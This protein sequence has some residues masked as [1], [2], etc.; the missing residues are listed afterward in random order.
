MNKL[1]NKVVP[2]QLR[3]KHLRSSQLVATLVVSLIAGCSNKAHE[4][5]DKKVFYTQEEM[6][7]WIFPSRPIIIGNA[8]CN[9]S[10]VNTG[11]NIIDVSIGHCID[12][13]AWSSGKK[14]PDYIITK[15][16]LLDYNQY[17]I[18]RLNPPSITSEDLVWK[19]VTMFGIKPKDGSH[20]TALGYE[21]E[22]VVKRTLSDGALEIELDQNTSGEILSA[23]S[24][25]SY[26][27]N[28][29]W[30]IVYNWQLVGV[31]QAE[32]TRQA[33]DKFMYAHGPEEIRRKLVHP[34]HTS[35][36]INIGFSANIGKPPINQ[37]GAVKTHEREGAVKTHPDMNTII[38]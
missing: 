32:N 25:W 19:T 8:W 6:E 29:W 17:P 9:A 34:T 11:E 12:N 15:N 13:D 30:P 20:T 23:L 2:G 35:W 24:T 36:P 28:S 1:I 18:K 37:E 38:D 10:Q 22:W 26:G 3:G 5:Q 4:E 16:N 33:R 14:R 27:G 31:V 7:S 21:V